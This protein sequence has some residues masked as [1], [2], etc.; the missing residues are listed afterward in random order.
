MLTLRR[1]LRREVMSV[2]DPRPDPPVVVPARLVNSDTRDVS[3][4][5]ILERPPVR[6]SPSPEALAPSAESIKL[7]VHLINYD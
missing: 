3:T 7:E 6:A 4:V 1:G 5:V 2:I